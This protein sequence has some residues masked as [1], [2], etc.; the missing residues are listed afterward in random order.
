M[1]PRDRERIEAEVAEL[2]GDGAADAPAL[3]AI[4]DDEAPSEAAPSPERWVAM[5]ALLAAEPG[6]A[7]PAVALPLDEP[8]WLRPA[9]GIIVAAQFVAVVLRGNPG[10][11]DALGALS[12]LAAVALA[13]GVLWLGRERPRAALVAVLGASVL[14]A[15]PHLRDLGFAWEGVAN[16][17]ITELTCAVAPLGLALGARLRGARLG[18]ADLAAVAAAGALAAQGA[19]FLLCPGSALLGH[20][21]VSHV[22][23]VLGAAIVGAGIGAVFGPKYSR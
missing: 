6:P 19:L 2:L 11:P 17:L 21:A 15:L 9:V 13:L 18:A 10:V 16:C 14:V 23:G 22:G 3:M 12:A 5:S 4:L 20:V 1:S 7:T 8:A